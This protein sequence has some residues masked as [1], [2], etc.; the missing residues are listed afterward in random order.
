[1][2]FT[3]DNWRWAGVP[4]YIRTGKRMTTRVSEITIQFRSAPFVLF[5]KTPVEHLKPNLLVVQIQPDEG[6]WLRFDAKVPGPEVKIGAVQMSFNYK[7][8]FGSQPSTGY[9]TLLY[10]CMI[11]DSTLFQRADMV[12]AGWNIVEPVLEHWRNKP[13]R[14][15]PVYPAGTWGPAEADRLMERDGR[16]WRSTM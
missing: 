16:H 13:D 15:I 14:E 4:F 9:E 5:R 8:Y 10:D 6:I 7:D 11:G 12:E 1:M 2:K 3:V